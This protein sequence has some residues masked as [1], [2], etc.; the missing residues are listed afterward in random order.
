MLPCAAVTGTLTVS[1][2]VCDYS[3]RTHLL[4]IAATGALILAACGGG[5]NA[6]P[7]PTA[8]TPAS[9]AT[10]T[11]FP[12]DPQP[13]I[14]AAA[15]PIAPLQPATYIVE[16][17]DTLSEVAVR[18]NTTVDA[19]ITL[20]ELTDATLI[21]VGQEL[22]LPDGGA[23]PA[24]TPGGGGAATGDPSVYVVQAGDTA[25]AI[26]NDHDTT[27]ELLAEANAITVD[28]LAA[29]QPGDTLTLPRP[30]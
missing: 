1:P 14:V 24:A 2:P 17:G 23:E 29:L 8:D 18:F 7:E 3:M 13:T 15:A 21:F 5:D 6:A 22:R 12:I 25:W 9:I 27:I 28:E 4:T 19:I 20:N 30:R 16:A 10:A 11:P 26:A